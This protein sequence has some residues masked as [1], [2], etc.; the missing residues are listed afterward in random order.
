MPL[1]VA[2]QNI[3]GK[4]YKE[5]FPSN[6]L[7]DEIL[8]FDDASFPLL[9]WIDPYSNT[10]FNTNQMRPLVRELDRLAQTLSH[11]EERELVA[12]IREIAVECQGKPQTYLRFIGD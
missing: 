12:K 1:K 8:P 5:I 11:E 10:T 2:F 6:G 7:L 9:G 4:R 3:D